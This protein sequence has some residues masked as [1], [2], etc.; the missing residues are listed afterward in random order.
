MITSQ[1]IKGFTDLRTDP[2]GIAD[3][4]KSQGPVYILN[5]STPVSV[6][7]DVAEYED[8]VERLQDALDTLE[9]A[10]MKKIAGKEDFVSHEELLRKNKLVK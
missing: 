9:I 5:R 6:L 10:E 3:L 8:M 1:T 2:M 7:L 4:A